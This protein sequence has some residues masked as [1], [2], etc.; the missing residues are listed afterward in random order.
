MTN[1]AYLA[2]LNLLLVAGFLAALLHAAMPDK[3]G[4]YTSLDRQQLTLLI[5][6]NR[7]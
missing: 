7:H 5:N 4:V 3:P 6:R 1:G 2:A